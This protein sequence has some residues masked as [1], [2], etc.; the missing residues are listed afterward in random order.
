MTQVKFKLELPAIAA[1]ILNNYNVLLIIMHQQ[2]TNTNRSAVT[3]K[4]TAYVTNYHRSKNL[5]SI[6][7]DSAI[8]Y[9]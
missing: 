5:Q 6:F 1:L 4:L 2:L 3:E 9:F 7:F 8:C